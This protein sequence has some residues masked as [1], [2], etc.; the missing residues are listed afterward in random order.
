MPNIEEIKSGFNDREKVLYDALINASVV[1]CG[2][3]FVNVDKVMNLIKDANAHLPIGNKDE[4]HERGLVAQWMKTARFSPHLLD[5]FVNDNPDLF[6]KTLSTG[7]PSELVPTILQ[8][9]ILEAAQEPKWHRQLCDVIQIPGIEKTKWAVSTDG[10]TADNIAQNAPSVA[11]DP[12]FGFI[13]IMTYEK[14]GHVL[15]PD[16]LIEVGPPSL[17]DLIARLGKNSIDKLEFREVIKGSGT[18]QWKGLDN[19]TFFEINGATGL[20]YDL[21]LEAEDALYDEDLANAIWITKSKARMLSL[22]DASGRYIFPPGTKSILDH[23]IKRHSLMET[24]AIYLMNPK[25]YGIFDQSNIKV[26]ITDAGY[27]LHVADQTLIAFRSDSDGKYLGVPNYMDGC[28]KIVGI[29][30]P[31]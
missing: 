28:V 8:S 27:T 21:L 29:S 3:Q 2:K 19:Y 1:E 6:V 12:T 11:S 31:A 24:D 23:D 26:R 18:N 25:R 5:K 22:K 14:K 30:T 16:K 17:V 20:S 15:I 4:M 13:D 7:S 10:V 9:K